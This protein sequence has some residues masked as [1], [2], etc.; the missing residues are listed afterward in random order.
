MKNL[1]ETPVSMFESKH[2]CQEDRAA[3]WRAFVVFGTPERRKFI[4]FQIR[5]DVEAP[6]VAMKQHQYEENIIASL[7]PL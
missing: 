4:S 2:G 6:Y 7:F 3:P 5:Y 1:R